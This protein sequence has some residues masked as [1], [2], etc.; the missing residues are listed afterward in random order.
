MIGDIIS[1]IIGAA[2]GFS[3]AFVVYKYK[4]SAAAKIQSTINDV[5][6]TVETQVNKV[7]DATKTDSK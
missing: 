4:A 3:G 7:A 5:T 2:L 6:A 1:G